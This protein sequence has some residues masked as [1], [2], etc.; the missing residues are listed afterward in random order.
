MESFSVRRCTERDRQYNPPTA[1]AA[2][3]SAAPTR[4]QVRRAPLVRA[5]ADRRPFCGSGGHRPALPTPRQTCEETAAAVPAELC[6]PEACPPPAPPLRRARTSS[7]CR[8][9]GDDPLPRICIALQPLQ[10]RAHVRGVLIAQ[11]AVF[12]QRLVDDPFQL[13][14][15][16]RVQPHGRGRRAFRMASKIIAEVSPRKGSAPGRHL[17]EHHAKREQIAA[18]VQFLASACSGDM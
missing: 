12:L 1:S 13:R 15:D 5:S 10:L 3:R 4:I 14:G 16:V 18:R 9:F 2:M 8:L 6:A 7:V 11:V 17:V